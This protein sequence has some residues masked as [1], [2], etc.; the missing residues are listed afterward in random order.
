MRPFDLPSRSLL[1][2]SVAISCI[3]NVVSAHPG[4]DTAIVSSDHPLHSFVEPAHFIG[5]VAIASLVLIGIA[6]A[7]TYRFRRN[8]RNKVAVPVR[9]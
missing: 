4:H 6:V 5:P 1:V 8:E 3:A 7:T 9:K 2:T